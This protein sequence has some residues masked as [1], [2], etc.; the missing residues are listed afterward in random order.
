MKKDIILAGVGGQGILSIAAVIDYAALLLGYKVKQAEVHGMSQRGGA[1]QSNLRISDSE[2][3]SDLIALSRADLIISV[4]PM[5]SLRYVPYLSENGWVV[6]SKDCFKNIP[7][8][9]D[10]EVLYGQI[11]KLPRKIAVEAEKIAREAGSVKASNMVMLGVSAP[12]LDIPV[13]TLKKA[14]EAIFADKGQKIIDINLRAF[15]AGLACS[16]TMVH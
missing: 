16:K 4:E 5:E 6:T 8:Y 9:P 7:N 12:F 1:V 11:E 3:F 13:D 2:I 15:D 10:E 14:I